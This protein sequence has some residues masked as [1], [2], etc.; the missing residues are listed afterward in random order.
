MI[1]VL[2][3][4]SKQPESVTRDREYLDYSINS[5]S[6][7]KPVWSSFHRTNFNFD[8]RIFENVATLNIDVT[9]DRF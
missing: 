3:T 1:N 7:W 8:R 5:Q 2:R 6:D 4:I 9:V